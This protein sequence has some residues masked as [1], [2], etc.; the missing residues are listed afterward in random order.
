M[1]KIIFSLD[2]YHLD[3]N[4]DHFSFRYLSD[5]FNLNFLLEVIYR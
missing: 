3:K 1:I 5:K 4:T 2:K